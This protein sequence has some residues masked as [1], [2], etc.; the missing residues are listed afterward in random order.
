LVSPV[1]DPAILAQL[2]APD[3][4]VT[5]PKILAELN[6]PE[7]QAGLAPSQSGFDDY[8]QQK[9]VFW[10]ALRQIGSTPAM[11]PF[12]DLPD[13][14]PI[15]KAT[16]DPMTDLLGTAKNILEFPA[17]LS[18][19]LGAASGPVSDAVATHLGALG[20]P[21]PISAALAMVSGM[22]VDPRNVAMMKAGPVIEGDITM[23]AIAGKTAASNVA[24]AERFGIDLTVGQA[25]QSRV[26]G[27]LEAVGNRFPFSADN[28]NNFFKN[29]LAQADGVRAKLV[30]TLGNTKAA[31]IVSK[32]E[33]DSIDKYLQTATPEQASVLA[34][35]FQ[36]IDAYMRKPASSEFTQSMLAQQRKIALDAAGAPFDALRAIV[37]DEAPIK[38]SSFASKAKEFLDQEMQG[39]VSDRK[40]EWVKRLADYAGVDTNALPTMSDGTPMVGPLY[41]AIA[42]ALGEQGKSLA[43]EMPY[44][45]TQMT[46]RKLRDLRIANDPGY[47]LGIKGQGNTYAGYAAE[48]RG[49]LHDDIEGGLTTLSDQAKQ[50]LSDVPKN[51]SEL[52]KGFMYRG[53]SPAEASQTIQAG[54]ISSKS[55]P[56]HEPGQIPNVLGYVSDDPSEALFWGRTSLYKQLKEYPKEVDIAQFDK[57][58]NLKGMFSANEKGN[59]S[60][61]TPSGSVDPAIAEHLQKMTNVSDQY[62]AAK[63]NYAQTKEVVNDPF[64]IKLLKNDP[65]DFLD[66]AVTAKDIS[67]VSKLKDLLGKDNFVPVQQ[68]LL[69]N[70]LVDKSGALNP[71]SFVNKVDMIG[72]PTLTKVFDP[73][74]LTEIVHSQK[75]FR[76]MKSLESSVGEGSPTAGL[77]MAKGALF[78]TTVK[79]YHLLMSGHPFG[80][81][82]VLGSEAA[83]P[84]VA[85][86]MYLS[87]VFRDLMLHAH[88]SP[89]EAAMALSVMAKGLAMSGAAG[90][91][92]T[93]NEPEPAGIQ[94]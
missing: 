21:A 15:I 73:D 41:D 50:A 80:A 30:E 29:E 47:L 33:K 48:L 37:P 86:K 46:M 19:T 88:T 72:Y 60:K 82:A 66:H 57:Q 8:L 40:S 65:E 51:I 28:F 91:R 11:Q 3:K 69:A 84:Y 77:L 85:S 92:I 79:A 38:T 6:A 74:T 45:A 52:P 76:D 55:I 59:I 78:G 64:I 36:N 42:K 56:P 43:A 75:V 13:S 14:I 18:S 34:D 39:K 87:P 44:G 17:R 5:D 61:G 70:M 23:P 27:Y 20:L 2:N 68:N 35:K 1:T 71:K 83:L 58:G 93:T 22:A 10:N 90:P 53:M 24:Q 63:A 32:M 16:G 7:P 89:P 67:N 26:L 31:E 12:K 25:S 62:K 49:A 81:A 54:T 94:Q 9:G 4:P